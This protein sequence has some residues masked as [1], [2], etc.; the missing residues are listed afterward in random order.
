M[1]VSFSRRTVQSARTRTSAWVLFGLLLM[2]PA[3]LALAQTVATGGLRG[4]VQAAD[5]GPLDGVIVTLVREEL[6]WERDAVADR[7]GQFAFLFLPPGD[8]Q[9]LVERLGYIPLRVSAVRIRA[10]RTASAPLVLRPSAPPIEEVDRVDFSRLGVGGLPGSESY[11]GEDLVRLPVRSGTL[12]GLG[13]GV[14]PAAAGNRNRGLP[15]RFTGLVI[16]G[17][18]YQ[19]LDIPAGGPGAVGQWAWP[20]QAFEA[21]DF[22]GSGTDVEWG[23]DVSAIVQ[24]STRPGG[25]RSAFS[26]DLGTSLGPVG[27]DTGGSD[28]LDPRA[29][30]ELTAVL[31]GPIVPDTA[32]YRLL[33]NVSRRADPLT[34][35]T[36]SSD[37]MLD[38]VRQAAGTD[39]LS[40]VPGGGVATTDQ[41]SLFGR[42]DWDFGSDVS[43]AVH[44]GLRLVRESAWDRGLPRPD[45][46]RSS[47]ASRQLMVGGNL[48]SRFGTRNA[49]EVRLGVGSSTVER[50]LGT[51]GSAGTPTST[52]VHAGSVRTA[53]DPALVGTFGQTTLH[54][55]TVLHHLGDRH[56]IK[57]GL[58]VDVG[59]H[60]VSGRPGA[61]LAF[62]FPT[63]TDLSARQG[64]LA[65]A[66][67]A[68]ADAAF[69]MAGIGV[70]VQDRWMLSP[71]FDLTGALRIDY[72]NLPLEDRPR[73]EAWFDVSGLD[74]REV[75]DARPAILPRVGWE[76]RPGRVVVAGGAGLHRGS[77]DVPVLLEAL[78]DTGSVRV[79]RFLG[80]L[81][82]WPGPSS[83]AAEPGATGRRLAI[84]G[85]RLE[86]PR[87]RVLD[88][89]I[90]A[91]I[92]T[93]IRAEVAV[94]HRRTEF[95][96]RVRDLNLVQGRFALDQFGREVRGVVHRTGDLIAI[97]P[98]S[99]RR[100]GGFDQVLAL[101]TDGW[102]EWTGVTV[103]L[104]HA[105]P[106]ERTLRASYTASRSTDN[107]PMTASGWP[108]LTGAR[109]APDGEDPSWVEGPSDLHRPHEFV[110]DGH[111]R[112]PVGV[113]VTLG[114]RYSARS[115]APFTPTVRDLLGDLHLTSPAAGQPLSLDGEMASL[116][117]S[118]EGEWPCL[119]ELRGGSR[120]RNQ[121][122]TE[123]LHEL[124]ARLTLGLPSP[125]GTSW[126]LS[127][128]AMN[129]LDARDPYPDPALFIVDG[130][131]SFSENPSAG[132]IALPVIL[133]PGFG[134]S[135]NIP[136]P[137][138]SYRVGL[139]VRF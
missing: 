121:C 55:A 125:G 90:S 22:V 120:A 4:Q 94:E 19:G 102:S 15:V 35:V 2:L 3:E 7:E 80:E 66:Q 49:F 63:P 76:W 85:P 25:N 91:P 130:S 116:A 51:T 53:P 28:A 43:L 101:E 52:L 45:P 119:R 12:D 118:L 95:L 89:S 75:E 77:L 41:G 5:G 74:T 50:D 84:L 40:L 16:D 83:I 69:T 32:R 42:L 64:A 11:L 46:E 20:L 108:L 36:R 48:L 33:L 21:I 129:I 86:A 82:H 93:G 135:I 58:A 38:A 137:G 99:D 106:G 139:T 92:G 117:S 62:Q 87:A 103:A 128:D 26:L 47:L 56:R 71:S 23:G 24:A 44:S 14:G 110:A 65:S 127:L 97:R 113:D 78:G 105:V 138:R 81:G 134:R 114:G 132:T 29:S 68:P 39:G 126:S 37:A 1:P 112:I 6:G 18:A 124:D 10:G 123:A 17:I 72:Q 34:F 104:V 131:R 115:G 67:G 31:S 27:L 109:P 96:T 111:I 107:A 73:N 30:P 9:L 79:D 136:S 88:L 70:F 61:G 100:F 133:N 57:A 13:G 54:L 122:R 8:Y 98:G 60:D 59:R